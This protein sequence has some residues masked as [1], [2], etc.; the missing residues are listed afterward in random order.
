MYN[1]V[2]S[3]DWNKQKIILPICCN[4]CFKDIE[5]IDKLKYTDF[6]LIFI[7]LQIKRLI[8]ETD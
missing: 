2:P 1:Q 4:L 6:A 3:I 5:N 7:Q 8:T